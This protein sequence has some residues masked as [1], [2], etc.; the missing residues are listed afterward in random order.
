MNDNNEH[1]TQNELIYSALIDSLKNIYSAPTVSL[2]FEPMNVVSVSGGAV[3][4]SLPDNRREF[5]A[6]QFGTVIKQ[7][8]SEILGC[9][10]DVRFTA[11]A[12]YGEVLQNEPAEEQNIRESAYKERFSP[13]YT[14]K[15]FVVGKSNQLAQSAALAVAK[16]PAELNNPLFLY[17]NSGLGK[18]HLMFAIVN[19]IRCDHPDYNILYVTGEEF[20]N[21][22]IE[23]LAQK[24]AGLFREK[25]RRVDVL[26]IDDIQ[27]IAGK[28]GIQEE[29]FYTFDALYT[30]N[31]QII[32][33]SDRAPRDINNLEDRLKS[34]FEMGLVADI[35]PPDRELRM[36]IF[37]R[38]AIDY[39]FNLEMDVLSYLADNITTNIRQLE[40]S[41]KK[42]KAHTLITGE[43]CSLPVAKT[44][45]SEY[46]SRLRSDNS[47]IDQIF[48]AVKTRFG[49]SREELKSSKRNSEIVI[50]RHYAIYV[51][52]KTTNLSQKAIANI[53]NK[54]D[55]STII[56]SISY[57]ETKMDSDPSFEREI[58]Q[59]ISEIQ[60]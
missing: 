23:V 5:V 53:F 52:R 36:A 46:F 31:K 17:G 43:K 2:W 16:H 41:L 11:E 42:L 8:L 40:G 55:H 18:T 48:D 27:F 57:I 10:A 15:N 59:L 19:E 39:G 1:K 56:N 44:V 49:V 45:L 14:F 50:A 37:K 35:Q 33:A 47:T 20:T 28:L 13:A 6:S 22:L 32:I 7:K 21:E 3:T 51:I 38:K 60:N 30:A 9:E 25:Y 24:K 4:V 54:K 12:G 58:N 34:R 29:F 26:L